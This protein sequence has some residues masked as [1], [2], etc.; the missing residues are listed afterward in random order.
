[1]EIKTRSQMDPEFL[2]DLTAIF[3]SE[4]AWRAALDRA[5]AEV[6]ALKD[7]PGTL[8]RSA[9][10]LLAGLD[11]IYA[12]GEQAERVY[13]YAFLK[14]SGDGGDAA[15]QEMEAR[16]IGLLVA[17]QT[18][19]A[20]VNP[21]ILRIPTETLQEWLRDERL[22]RYRHLAEDLERG[23]AHTL[24]AQSERML[25]QL[26]DA[27]QTPGNAFQMLASVD[28]RFP[29]VHD[30]AGNELPLTHGSFGVYRDG[31]DRRLRREAFENYFGEY[32]KYINTLA[33]LYAGNVKQDCF[34]ADIRG[35]G[36]ACEA[37]LF[38]NNVPVQL[39]DALT[40]AVHEALP[41]MR[42]YIEL[43]R[44]RLALES[45]HLYDLYAPIVEDVEIEMP[46]E[47]A[48]AL[49]KAALRPLGEEYQSLLDRAF[50]E[51]W[52][53]VYENQGKHTG[54]YSM[55]VYGAHPYVLLNYTG[56]LDDAFTLAHEL[57]H[58][59][60]SFF[61][62]RAQ[63][64]V[65][66]DYSI[67]VAEVASTVNEV[68][69]TRYLLSVETDEARRAMLLNHFVEGFRTTIFRQTLFAEFERRA[70]GMYQ[71]GTPL[72]AEALNGLYH[73]LNAQYYDGCEI[74]GFCDVEWARI[75]H[76]YTAFYVY[77][78]A[79]GFSSAVAIADR[80]L[81]TGDASDYLRF[82]TTGGSDYPIEELK[83]AGV[84]LTKPDAVRDA[85]AAFRGAVRQLKEILKA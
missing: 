26:G 71:S 34:N 35:F 6:E 33:A 64:Y 31:R 77:Q 68:L 59:M 20:F 19:T 82:L 46:F 23:R 47:K 13:A 32:A 36:G 53:D 42:E 74:D 73:E 40:D 81:R 69:L 12:A 80:I 61:S 4:D 16:A 55:G 49:V 62:D 21:E 58:A 39:Y 14:K 51:Q 22:K 84:D 1:M 9:E 38:A 11:R 70:H 37:A 10:D 79:T 57:G 25:A 52:I 63:D 60:H 5:Q 78:Y 45:I 17:M 8:G 54:A 44:E 56:K 28:M 76:F 7:I 15:C 29:P 66:H 85:M 27:F 72:T 30:D 75:P 3:P 24:D 43:R 41:A 18:A 48:K 50:R 2:W 67:F 65:N 83:I